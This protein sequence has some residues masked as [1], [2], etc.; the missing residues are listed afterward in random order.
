MILNDDVRASRLPITRA[1]LTLVEVAVVIAIIGILIAILIPAIQSA[2]EASRRVQ[3][4][5]N[6]RQLGLAVN[7]YQGVCGV[8]SAG[9]NNRGY[10]FILMILPYLEQKPLYDSFN[11]SAAAS[12]LP[13]SP[14]DTAVHVTLGL[15]HCPSDPRSLAIPGSTCYAGNKGAGF[16]A[17]G[18]NG[19][20][21]NGVFIAPQSS[22]IGNQSI[23]DGAS[24]TAMIAEWVV[25]PAHLAKINPRWL[26]YSVARHL[27]APD[28]FDL[29]VAE[30]HNASA[31]QAAPAMGKG[32]EWFRGTY[33]ETLYNHVEVPNDHSCLNGGSYVQQGAWTAGSLHPQ[34]AN[35]LFVD[36]HCGFVRGSVAAKVWRALGT[37]NGAEVI[38]A[39]TF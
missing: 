4:A 14:N 31:A 32:G 5:A 19:T 25:T 38:S 33:P 21:D 9:N 36:G 24:S 30:C 39:N 22:P 6:L 10:S 29:F 28:Q 15:L 26:T 11:F 2:L 37:R 27:V 12:M 23:S 20:C 13:P 34:G 7:Q 18:P 1:G 16:C 8:F 35:I 3:C 17:G